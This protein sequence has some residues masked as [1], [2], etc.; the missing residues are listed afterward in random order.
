MKQAFLR[1]LSI[2]VHGDLSDSRKL[3]IQLGTLDAYW[4]F[5]CIAVYFFIALH[6]KTYPIAILHFFSMNLII[7]GLWLLTKKHYDLGRFLIH[8]ICIYEVFF[9]V[10]CYPA[11][12]GIEL[13]Y[14]PTILIPFIT[15]SV[16]EQWK[17]NIQVF[18]G[19][20]AYIAQYFIGTGVVFDINPMPIDRGVAIGFVLSYMPLILGFLRW[21][22]KDT[23]D[24]LVENQ[25]ELLHS[26]TMKVIGEMSVNLAHEI[27]NPLQSLSLQLSVL[28]D[29][30][31]PATKEEMER[32]EET[33]QKMGKMIQGIKELGQKSQKARQEFR[34]SKLLEDILILSSDRIKE[35]GIQI[36]I[37]GDS[38]LDI[39]GHSGEIAQVLMNLLDHAIHSVKKTSEKGI[40]LDLREK[41]HFL[42]ITVTTK[43]SKESQWVELDISK[44]IVERNKGSLFLDEST[45]DQKH[46]MLLPLS[47]KI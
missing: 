46:V 5:V 4:S 32:M 33:I 17:G 42:Q 29:K 7:V 15:F 11:N 30:N 21:Q 26:S 31:R 6:F 2:G 41:N 35:A 24:K 9:T 13:F 3:A 1:A 47:G 8:F 37:N 20:L 27:N 22:V 44:S 34:F 28:K 40:W 39:S 16:D 23:K 10:D 18:L 14:I 25:K 12:S 36:Y 38:E 45:D 19:S 43:V